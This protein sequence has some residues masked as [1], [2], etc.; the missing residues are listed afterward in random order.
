LERNKSKKGTS[1]D[2]LNRY[3]TNENLEFQLKLN[4]LMVGNGAKKFK[5]NEERVSAEEGFGESQVGKEVSRNSVGGFIDNYEIYLNRFL[6]LDVSNNTI[7]TSGIHESLSP[8]DLAMVV[9][10]CVLSNTMSSSK[11]QAG[12][13]S[14]VVD[15]GQ[16]V[17]NLINRMEIL[18]NH[19]GEYEKLRDRLKRRE[20]L[21]NKEKVQEELKNLS[22]STIEGFE[23]WDTKKRAKVGQILLELLLTSE[24]R[25]EGMEGLFFSD[26]FL[27]RSERK[28]SGKGFTVKKT[29]DISEAG[30]L[31]L[32]KNEEYLSTFSISY[33]PTVI[34]PRNWVNLDEGGYYSEDV[35]RQVKSVKFKTNLGERVTRDLFRKY[36]EGFE[37]LFETLN[38]LQST[39][40]RVNEYVWDAIN[41]VNESKTDLD[42][43]GVPHYRNGWEEVLGKEK[44][45]E[46]SFIRKFKETDEDGRMTEEYKQVLKDFERSCVEDD[47]PDDDVWKSFKKMKSEASKFSRAEKSKKILIKNTLKDAKMF[48][49]KDIFFV[50]NADYRGRIY[51]V[52]SQFNPQGSDVSKGL[53]SF[54]REVQVTDVKAIDEIAKA[55]AGNYGVDKVSLKDRIMWTELHTKEILEC[56]EDFKKTDF[57]MKADKPYLFLLSCL[58][59]KKVIDAR[60]SGDPLNFKTNLPIA[61]D[62][63]I[64]GVQHFSALFR[65]PIGATAVNLTDGETPTDAYKEVSDKALEN[66]KKRNNSMDKL[67]VNL[68]N[69]LGG[70]LFS[71]AASKRSVID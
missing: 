55:I 40:F 53:F 44:A 1:M 47:V 46:Y 24:V 57:W 13:V 6:D 59:W 10:K 60:D 15:I 64:N 42:C 4:E 56:A 63:S 16:Q 45:E 25:T 32:D 31:W 35:A 34:P 68:N 33:L 37:I 36:P 50:F 41:W 43:K 27:D 62:G 66:C 22:K 8:S 5:K 48:F 38:S 17:E 58:E 69:K 19:E 9:L 51:P 23:V 26:L 52:A 20:E 3:F 14:L 67:V 2:D 65:D 12:I 18:L 49:G 28:F 71:R 30:L 29:L 61:F 21:G 70:T 11:D 39:P 7:V 54:A